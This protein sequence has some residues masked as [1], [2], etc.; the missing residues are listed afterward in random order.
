MNTI[1]EFTDG[2]MQLAHQTLFE[3]YG[4]IVPL[5]V[6]D[7]ELRLDP[8]SEDLSSCPSLYWEER[9]AHF[10]VSKTG[11]ARFRCQFFYSDVEQFGTGRDEYDS[12]GDCLVTLLRV[13]ADHER[14]KAGVKNGMTAVDFDKLG[15][16]E[17][18]HPPLII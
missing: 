17:E 18:Y 9:G 2:E 8:A 10:V 4:R 13:Q 3:R 6:A 14:E 15:D 5:Q 1:P 16:D 11:D 7:V 12:L